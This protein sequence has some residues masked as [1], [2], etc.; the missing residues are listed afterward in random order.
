M[1][2]LL[3][4]NSFSCNSIG[5]Q[6]NWELSSTANIEKFD[7]PG[8]LTLELLKNNEYAAS[9]WSKYFLEEFT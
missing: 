3:H 4:Y 8:N 6:I 1:F 5:K 7:V 9:F 2:Y